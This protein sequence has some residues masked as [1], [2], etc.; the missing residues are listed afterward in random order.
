MLARR[1]S[2]KHLGGDA[3]RPGSVVATHVPTHGWD[4]HTI[5]TKRPF[6]STED[7]RL[8]LKR[9]RSFFDRLLKA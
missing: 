1:G 2:C 4:S 8:A 6:V 7:L 5:T 3:E 9:Y